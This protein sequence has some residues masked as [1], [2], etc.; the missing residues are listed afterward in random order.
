L[1]QFARDGFFSVEQVAAANQQRD[2]G[3]WKV[4]LNALHVYPQQQP[5]DHSYDIDGMLYD[6]TSSSK[7]HAA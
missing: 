7:T 5:E 2:F 1:I 4:I 3:D 6:L